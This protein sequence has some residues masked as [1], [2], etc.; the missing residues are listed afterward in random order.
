MLTN[1]K[2]STKTSDRINL[3]MSIQNGKEIKKRKEVKD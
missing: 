1:K 3:A 2:T